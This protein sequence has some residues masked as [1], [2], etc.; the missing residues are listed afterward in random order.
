MVPLPPTPPAHAGPALPAGSG[1][2]AAGPAQQ[3]HLGNPNRLWEEVSAS[4]NE[5]HVAPLPLRGRRARGFPAEGGRGSARCRSH[6]EVRG[7]GGE[8]G[9]VGAGERGNRPGSSSSS[10]SRPIPGEKPGQDADRCPP[11]SRGRGPWRAGGLRLRPTRQARAPGWG[12]SDSEPGLGSLADAERS[13]GKQAASPLSAGACKQNPRPPTAG[14]TAARGPGNPV[15]L[16]R[17]PLRRGQGWVTAWPRGMAEPRDRPG[18]TVLGVR[19]W[20]GWGCGRDM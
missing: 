10:S 3:A 17:E 6:Q 19:G 1:V 16:C 4:P 15:R 13:P 5:K 8:P 12:L 7:P 9:C 18:P 2:G 14:V 11:P 20:E